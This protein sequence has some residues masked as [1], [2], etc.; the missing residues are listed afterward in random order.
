MTQ[1]RTHIKVVHSRKGYTGIVELFM[2]NKI[3][4]IDCTESLKTEWLAQR[5]A[6]RLAAELV[7]VARRAA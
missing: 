4:L 1:F 2:G 3:I 6:E 5:G 7:G